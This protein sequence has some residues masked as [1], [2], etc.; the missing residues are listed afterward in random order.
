MFKWRTF[1]PPRHRSSGITTSRSLLL[2]NT[3]L[4]TNCYAPLSDLDHPD[5][6]AV[7][8]TIVAVVPLSKPCPHSKHWWNTDLCAIRKEH[9]K[10]SRTSHRLRDIPHHPSH[11]QLKAANARYGKAICDAKTQYWEEWLE[12]AEGAD[13]WT[14]NQFLTEPSMDGGKTH[15]PTLQRAQPDGSTHA[16]NSNEEKSHYLVSSF[17]PPPPA[18]SSVPPDAD[19]PEPLDNPKAFTRARIKSQL[20]KLSPYK[21]PGPDGIPN[22]VLMCSADHI[23]NH[24]YYIYEALLRLDTYYGP[25]QEFTTVVLRKPEKP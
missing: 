16:V 23:V 17:F 7:C 22:V 8:C 11:E 10:L 9:N 18:V 13:V 4:D 2:I 15:I 3:A 12:E 20:A 25:W 21:V 5:V 1:Y 19:Y 24:L 14:A 6:M